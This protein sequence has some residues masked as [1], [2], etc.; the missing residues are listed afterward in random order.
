MNTNTS[1]K[2]KKEYKQKLL[3]LLKNEGFNLK[4]PFSNVTK[5]IC[6]QPHPDDCDL[7]IGGILAKLSRRGVKI[8]YVT[9]TDG[10]LG[11]YDEYVKPEHVAK[12]R[13]VEQRKAAKIIGVSEIVEL[14]LPDGNLAYVDLQK[15]RME[16]IKIIRSFKPDVVFI[17]D[18]WVVDEA[19]P[20]HRVG[21]LI[22]VE[23][24]MFSDLP[25][26]IVTVGEEVLK[27]HSVKYVAMYYTQRW[28]YIEDVTETIS[29]KIKALK[30]HESQFK[31]I[32]SIMEKIVLLEASYYGSLIGVRYG[33][34]L[35]ILP[36]ILLHYPTLSYLI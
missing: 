23:A 31:S 20:D 2:I 15:V 28:N 16:L 24:L 21:G 10:S 25:T 36:M 19:H 17:P 1:F 12:I 14:G 33:E 35:R 13:R 8:I 30:A 5:A 26:I 32:W 27:P 18:P 29:T 3:E 34:P 22:S 7:A 4:E 11:Y 9:L 6:I